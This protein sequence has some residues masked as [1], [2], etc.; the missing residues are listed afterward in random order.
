MTL[1]GGGQAF[2]SKRLAKALDP[3]FDLYFVTEPDSI[4]E[5]NEDYKARTFFNP[6]LVSMTNPS[7]FRTVRLLVVAIFRSFVII[8][9]FRPYGIIGVQGASAI[10]LMIAGTFFGTKRVYVETITRPTRLSLTARILLKCRLIDRV[11]VQWPTL[12]TGDNRIVYRG[13]IL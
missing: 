12:E 13:T 1:G 8:S 11:Y 3:L 4:S 7:R 5:L 2:A 6:A 9:R 10:P